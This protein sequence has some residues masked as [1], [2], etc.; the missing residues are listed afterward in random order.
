MQQRDEFPRSPALPLVG[1]FRVSGSENYS[2]IPKTCYSRCT[3]TAD[4]LTQGEDKEAVGCD[5]SP[6][7]AQSGADVRTLLCGGLDSHLFI[8]PF[9]CEL[10]E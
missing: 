3:R 2:D 9:N 7:P 1:Q 8:L 6:G 10:L 5:L 4:R